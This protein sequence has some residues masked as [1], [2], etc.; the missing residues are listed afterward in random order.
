MQGDQVGVTGLEVGNLVQVAVLVADD[1]PRGEVL[2]AE[3]LDQAVG[4]QA[5]CSV[6]EP[7]ANSSM[8]VLPGRIAPASLRRSLMWASYGLM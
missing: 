5:E 4:P 2:R 6:E 7:M 3:G 8:L 1:G